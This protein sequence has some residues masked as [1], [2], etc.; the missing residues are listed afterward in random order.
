MILDKL[1]YFFFVLVIWYKYYEIFYVMVI[2][3]MYI[4]EIKILMLIMF[5]C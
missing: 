1:N 5:E 2:N 4:F 3:E